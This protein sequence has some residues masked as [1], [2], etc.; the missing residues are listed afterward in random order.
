MPHLW[1]AKSAAHR[2]LNSHER[3]R[4]AVE[5]WLFTLPTSPAATSPPEDEP[6]EKIR[7][8][9]PRRREPRRGPA[10]CAALS[11]L[12]LPISTPRPAPAA[13]TRGAS[14]SPAQRGRGGRGLPAQRSG[15]P[16][17]ELAAERAMPGALGLARD[18][19]AG[20]LLRLRRRPPRATAPRDYIPA[21]RSVSCSVA[22]ITPSCTGEKRTFHGAWPARVNV[23]SCSRPSSATS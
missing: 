11:S 8:P 3:R 9:S 1:T 21:S 14:P 6:Q 12:P 23:N 10:V 18:A 20:G 2:C 17:P 7:R 22:W 15:S 16:G 19:A 5:P 4:M 13:P